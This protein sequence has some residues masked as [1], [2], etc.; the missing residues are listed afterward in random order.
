MAH[1]PPQLTFPGL[2]TLVPNLDSRLEAIR[3][4]LCTTACEVWI[5]I[6]LLV[7]QFRLPNPSFCEGI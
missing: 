7:Q 3:A 4:E 5:E 6:Q 1:S 2:C